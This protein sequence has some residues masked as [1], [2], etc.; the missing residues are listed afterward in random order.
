MAACGKESMAGAV[1]GRGGKE[2]V[3][4]GAG[5]SVSRKKF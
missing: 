3:R 5:V 4:T 1:A 2:K